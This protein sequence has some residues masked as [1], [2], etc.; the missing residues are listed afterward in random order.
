MNPQQESENLAVLIVSL[1]NEA[2]SSAG[3]I[4]SCARHF[5]WLGWDL[6]T[7]G[8]KANT[9]FEQAV[10]VENGARCGH[11]VALC[12]VLE[13]ESP[14]LEQYRE[15]LLARPPLVMKRIMVEGALNRI[16]RLLEDAR[17]YRD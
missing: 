13:S 4:E 1:Y 16:A 9:A 6:R 15:I 2:K 3:V 14:V 11:V 8:E 5:G 17:R 10:E 7:Q 12:E